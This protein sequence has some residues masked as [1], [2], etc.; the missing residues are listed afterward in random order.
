[1]IL[2]FFFLV[3]GSGCSVH[4]LPDFIE[5]A[6][7]LLL[8]FFVAAFLDFGIR[9]IGNIIL[10]YFLLAPGITVAMTAKASLN[11]AALASVV[12]SDSV[13]STW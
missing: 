1:M 7:E 12:S 8:G 5:P 10:Y 13:V 11:A 4:D 9:F 6:V 2:T 3:T